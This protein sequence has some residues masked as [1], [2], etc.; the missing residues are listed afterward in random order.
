PDVIDR[1]TFSERFACLNCGTSIPEL[2]PRIFSFNSPH[3]ACERCHGL[4]FQRVVD[5]ELVVP[6][7]TLSLNEGALQPWNRGVTAYWRR[8]IAAVADDYEVDADKPWAKLRK[9]E[10]EVFL[11]GTGGERHQVTY[12]NRYGRRRSYKVR[13]EGIVNQL[14]RRYEETDSETNRERIESYMA[15]Q[16]CPDCKGARLRPESLGVTVGGLSIAAYTDLS[17][18]AASEWIQALELTETERAI[19]RLIVREISERLAFLRSEERRVG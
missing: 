4:G 10:K 19:A 7:P 3:G 2:E 17:A 5:P 6:D 14:Q 1:L 9:S 8:L 13:F 15:E 11:H 16:P 12:T 18:R